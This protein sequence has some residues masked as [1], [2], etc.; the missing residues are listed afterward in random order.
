MGMRLSALESVQ[1]A[2]EELIKQAADS[3]DPAVK[4]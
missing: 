4:G 1:Q 3:N 2:A